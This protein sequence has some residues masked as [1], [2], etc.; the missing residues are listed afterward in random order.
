MQRIVLT[1]MVG[2]LT[3]LSLLKVAIGLHKTYPVRPTLV[4]TTV[5]S[6]FRSNAYVDVQPCT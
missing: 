5:S 3:L 2:P 4:S 6:L 1:G